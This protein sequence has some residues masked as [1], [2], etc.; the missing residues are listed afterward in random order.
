MSIKILIKESE[1]K[2]HKMYDPNSD[3][4]IDAESEE[5]HIQYAEKDYIHIDPD[6]LRKIIGPDE[7]GAAGI[8]AFEDAL[9][10][11]D[12]EEIEDA[13]GKMDDIGKHFHGDYV[14]QDDETEKT[15]DKI[16]VQIVQEEIIRLFLEKKK[17]GVRQNKK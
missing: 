17:G 13:L 9:S 15:K 6:K 12:K 7:G 16:L 8:S 3:D 4:E 11:F 14:L 5:E 2:S 1:F 10:D